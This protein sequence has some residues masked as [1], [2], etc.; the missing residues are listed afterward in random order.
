V[1]EGAEELGRL[2]DTEPR[3]AGAAEKRVR[4]VVPLQPQQRL[5]LQRHHLAE[6]TARSSHAFV[7]MLAARALYRVSCSSV[8]HVVADQG[9]DLWSTVGAVGRGGLRFL[10]HREPVLEPSRVVALS[11]AALHRLRTGNVCARGFVGRLLQV[12]DG[13]VSFS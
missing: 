3:R 5:G 7:R 11:D 12:V 2:V 9:A 10:E 1:A 4:F 6:F 13:F 8:A